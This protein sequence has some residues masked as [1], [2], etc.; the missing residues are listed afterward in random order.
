M[1]VSGC[2]A[3]PYR[4]DSDMSDE[5]IVSRIMDKAAI[6]DRQAL[7]AALQAAVA[8]I[9][10]LQHRPDLSGAPFE[11]VERALDVGAPYGSPEH[12]ASLRVIQDE[13]IRPGFVGLIVDRKST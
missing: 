8:A 11:R 9:V 2:G 1:G 6:A 3:R 5:H 10:D 12:L 7:F 4:K 13:N